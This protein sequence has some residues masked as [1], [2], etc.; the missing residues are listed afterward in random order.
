[1][2]TSGDVGTDD[3]IREL[4]NLFD[5][6]G[7]DSSQLVSRVKKVERAENNQIHNYPHASVIGDLLTMWNQNSKYVDVFGDPIPIRMKGAGR[8]FTRLALCC[9]PNMNARKLLLD[10]K[11]V[12]AVRIDKKTGLIHPLGRTIPVYEDK[13]L[14]VLHTLATLH[15]FIKT[16]RHNLKSEALNSDQ[17]FHRIAWNRQLDIREVPR[18][19]IWLKRHGQH[20]LE[21]ADNWLIK[22]AKKTGLKQNR[23]TRAQISIGLYLA[24]D[25]SSK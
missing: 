2:P 19:K 13:R 10:L 9:A 24:V 23:R 16:L 7:V 12:G 22:N 4:L 5:G 11:R 15:G 17:L 25:K 14:A 3:V 21:S 20:F 6:L 18:L 1:M 8:S